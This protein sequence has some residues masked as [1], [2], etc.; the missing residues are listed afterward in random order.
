MWFTAKMR[1]E[2]WISI[3]YVSSGILLTVAYTWT[4]IADLTKVRLISARKS[5]K[6]EISYYQGGA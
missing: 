6:T 3:G 1:E 2:R 5:T 4:E